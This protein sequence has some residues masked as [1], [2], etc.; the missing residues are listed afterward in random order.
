LHIYIP[1]IP[2]FSYDQ[3]RSFAETMGKILMSKIPNKITMEWSTAKRKG[4]VFFDYNQNSRGKTIASVWSVRPTPLATV[5]VPIEWDQLD[6][7]NFR[8]FTLI[9]VP[10]IFKSRRDP[11]R[12]VLEEKQDLSKIMTAMKD[13]A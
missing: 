8:D 2:K 4:K 1:T 5:S 3:T 13:L 10:N 6:N 12:S 11:W 9:T 7:F